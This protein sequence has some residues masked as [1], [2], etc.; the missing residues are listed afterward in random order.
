MHFAHIAGFSRGVRGCPAL[1]APPLSSACSSLL[2]C[3]ALPPLC[4][5]RCSVLS[6]PACPLLP[7]PAPPSLCL[8]CPPCG[9]VAH[10][11]YRRL[12]PS[13][14]V[15][16]A[17]GVL[18]APRRGRVG[19]LHSSSPILQQTLPHQQHPSATPVAAAPR[20]FL[21]TRAAQSG[22][23][24]GRRR[25]ARRARSRRARSRAE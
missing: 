22:G 8:S 20:K 5:L 25:G 12:T 9:G 2:P 19:F 24:L 18:L 7:C 4:P 21:V 17:P 1:S 13:S 16:K 6:P 11:S 15:T 14:E 23:W 10:R 3:P